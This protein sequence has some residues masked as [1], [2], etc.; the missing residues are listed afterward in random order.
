MATDVWRVWDETQR[1]AWSFTPFESVGPLKFGMTYDQVQAAVE[2]VLEVGTSQGDVEG[3]LWAEL[4]YVH[5]PA[6][7]CVGPAVTVYGDR[8][9]GL[10]GI[11]VNALRGPQVTLHG[12]EL[13]GQTPSQWQTFEW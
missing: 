3:V 1:P 6:R 2:G 10:A 4:R 9:I 11:A 12:T 5:R 7:G 8:S 13:V